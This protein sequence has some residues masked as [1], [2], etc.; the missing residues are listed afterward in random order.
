MMKPTCKTSMAS[1]KMIDDASAE[2]AAASAIATKNSTPLPA[3]LSFVLT[4]EY[5]GY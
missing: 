3:V 5:N 4:I 2:A 1:E